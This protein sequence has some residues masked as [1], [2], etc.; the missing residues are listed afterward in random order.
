MLDSARLF[1]SQMSTGANSL[2][3]TLTSREAA[4]L[5]GVSE[6]SVKRWADGGLLPTVK[7]AGGHRRFRP[8]DVAV[9]RRERLHTTGRPSARASA[10]TQQAR[11]AALRAG[12]KREET[13]GLMYDVLVGGHAEEAAAILVSLHL[14]GVGVAALADEVLCPAMRRVGD[15]WHQGELSVA[16]EHVATRAALEAVQA[17]RASAHTH[18]AHGRR[19]VCCAAE[20]DFH[21]LP[22]QVAALVLETRG[23]EVFNLG[24]STPFYALAEAIERFAPRLVC[25]ASTILEGLDRAAREYADVRKAAARVGAGLALGGA[26]FAEEGV[27]RRFPAE[28]YAEDFRQLERFAV[29]LTEEGEAG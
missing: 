4:R 18:A 6:A 17:L 28:L 5:L 14:E 23:W 2:R 3:K 7:T 21:E 16:Q 9:F 22:V 13:A 1:S 10:E 27:R 29:S 8:E 12:A 25:V 19:A 24:T 15:L 26:G 20:E 11:G